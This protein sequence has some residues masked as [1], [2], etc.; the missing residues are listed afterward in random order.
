MTATVVLVVVLGLVVAGVFAALW[1]GERSRAQEVGSDPE[2]LDPDPDPDSHPGS[3]PD[4][5]PRRDG[6]T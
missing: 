1:I 5:G 6:G 3:H 2:R 4:R